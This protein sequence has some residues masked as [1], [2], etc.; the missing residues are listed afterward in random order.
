MGGSRFGIELNGN[1][2]AGDGGPHGLRRETGTPGRASLLRVSRTKTS[3]A[4]ARPKHGTTTHWSGIGTGI[5]GIDGGSRFVAVFVDGQLESGRWEGD[6]R[7]HPPPTGGQL[8]ASRAAIPTP[9]WREAR[10][11]WTSS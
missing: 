11:R 1:D 5:A 9:I 2:G 3:S 8:R 4:S 7:A 6:G 10:W